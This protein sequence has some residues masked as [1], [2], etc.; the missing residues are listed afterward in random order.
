MSP[1]SINQSI[2]ILE[3]HHAIDEATQSLKKSGIEF[4]H[5]MTQEDSSLTAGASPSWKPVTGDSISKK[6]EM[7]RIRH[8]RRRDGIAA[9]ETSPIVLSDETNPNS[10]ERDDRIPG[11]ENLLGE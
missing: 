10:D 1:G 3:H 8:T 5:E 9:S 4:F 2:S 6:L 11:E 7:K